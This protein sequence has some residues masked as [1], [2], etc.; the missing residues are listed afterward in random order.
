MSKILEVNKCPNCSGKLVRSEDGLRLVCP[1]CGSEFEP[2]D[3]KEELKKE[4]ETARVEKTKEEKKEETKEEAAKEKKGKEAE[5]TSD[6]G[7]DEWFEARVPSKK[8]AKGTNSKKVINCFVKCAELGS[9]EKILKYIRTDLKKGSGVGMP[10][11]TMPNST[12][13]LTA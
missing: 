7:R 12:H 6:W 3:S 10:E 8:L 9:S 11:S 5:S 1:F 13:L 2:E 4:N